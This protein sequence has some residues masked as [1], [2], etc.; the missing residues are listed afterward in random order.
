[1]ALSDAWQRHQL[2][3]LESFHNRCLQI[4]NRISGRQLKVLPQIYFGPELP[5][6]LHAALEALLH[7]V[8]NRAQ[9][10]SD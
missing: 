4:A 2:S 3:N 7:G 5:E 1:M 10:V 9:T 8:M 6:P